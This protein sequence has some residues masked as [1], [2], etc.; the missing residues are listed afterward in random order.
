MGRPL[1]F[2]ELGKSW[3]EKLE[4]YF[5]IEVSSITLFLGLPFAIGLF[6][7]LSFELSHRLTFKTKHH[8]L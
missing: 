5:R 7:M 2:V 3:E 4:I 8:R 6:F 1:G